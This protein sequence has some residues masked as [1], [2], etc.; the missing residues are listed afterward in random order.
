[1][2]TDTTHIQRNAATKETKMEEDSTSE[3]S[4]ISWQSLI[5][6]TAIR[7]LFLYEIPYKFCKT[8]TL[9]TLQYF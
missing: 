4:P 3:R 2:S 1:M 7:R 9:K 8:T 5:I 6:S